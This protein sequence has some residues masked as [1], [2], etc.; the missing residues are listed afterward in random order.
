[1]GTLSWVG[2]FLR[3]YSRSLVPKPIPWF[4][5]KILFRV[6]WVW[7]II[8]SIPRPVGFLQIPLRSFSTISFL[9]QKTFDYISHIFAVSMQ[10]GQVENTEVW[11]LKYGN[12]SMEV[13]AYSQLCVLRSCCQRVTFPAMGEPDP[14]ISDCSERSSLLWCQNE[15]KWLGPIQTNG[16]CMSSMLLMFWWQW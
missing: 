10:P 7:H 8:R 12:G 16:E 14:G 15:F 5:L 3:D 2:A 13:S 1:M 6:K 9:L 4:S 11:K